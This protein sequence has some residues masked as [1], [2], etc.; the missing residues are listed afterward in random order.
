MIYLGN[1]Y[2]PSDGTGDL[3]KVGLPPWRDGLKIL[4]GYNRAIEK[5]AEKHGMV[6]RVDL[7]RTFLGHGVYCTHFWRSHYDRKD[8]HYWY[9]TNLED[10]NE[11]GYDA[12][13]RL[14][15]NE[16]VAARGKF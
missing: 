14:F 3:G 13:R 11:R 15:L 10:P 9:F 2:D 8:P 4:A 16:I 1:I 5:V 7:H 6:H 12:I